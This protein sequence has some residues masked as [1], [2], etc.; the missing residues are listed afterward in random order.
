MGWSILKTMVP[1]PKITEIKRAVFIGPH[2]DDIEI[3][4]GGTVHRLLRLGAEVTFIV[5][6]DGGCGSADPS[7]SVEEMVRIRME[8]AKNA[9]KLLGI[10]E[11]F[12]LLFPDCGDYRP[13]D[14]ALKIAPILAKIRPDA[15]FCPDPNM[16]SEIH[17]DHIR[18]GNASKTAVFMTSLPL[19]MKRNEIPFDE[20]WVKKTNS[21]SLWYYFTHRP[22][23]FVALNRTDIELKKQAILCHTSQ[24]PGLDST[25][26][27]LISTYMSYRLRLFGIRVFAP[28]ADGFFVMGPVH[29]HCF[30][31]VNHF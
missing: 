16:P 24:F 7:Q 23:R 28:W 4:A 8:E 20:E 11:V 21:P 1:L 5:C 15:V 9:A 6:L 27:K 26:W 10:K 29:Q 17:P 2:P 19:V 25:E 22:N 12:F 18:V 14:L 30:P 3:G 13:W 31:E